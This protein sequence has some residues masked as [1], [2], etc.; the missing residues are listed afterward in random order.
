MRWRRIPDRREARAEAIV[1]LGCRS[2]SRLTRRVER[3]VGLYREAA[4]PL[5]VLS[6]GGPGAEPEALVMRRQALAAG[7]PEAALVVEPASRN[8]WE[9]AC[10][11][12]F[13]LRQRSLRRIVLVSD[14]AHLLR[15]AL[16]FRLAGLEVARRAGVRPRSALRELGAFCREIA[17]FPKSLVRAGRRPPIQR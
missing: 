13:V 7:L 11:T 2:S 1:V 14:R 12:A 3:G 15:A 5:L 4:A 16:L 17:A 8:T 10:E 6:G 9:N